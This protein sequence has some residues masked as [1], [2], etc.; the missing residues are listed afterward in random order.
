MSKLVS[1]IRVRVKATLIATQTDITKIYQKVEKK[2]VSQEYM[3]E[4]TFLH[5]PKTIQNHL[6]TM[7]LFLKVL[8]RSFCCIVL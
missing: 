2:K 4:R 5:Y 7:L 1:K 6:S 8:V 3:L